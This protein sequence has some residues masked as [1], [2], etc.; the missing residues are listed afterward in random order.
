MRINQINPSLVITEISKQ[1][2][3]TIN[4]LLEIKSEKIRYISEHE[5]CY[6]FEIH[7]NFSEAVHILE[8]INKINIYKFELDRMLNK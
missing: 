7:C 1:H 5:F 6:L 2:L 4:V 8:L 3:D